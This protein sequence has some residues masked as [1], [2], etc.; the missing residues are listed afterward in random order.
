M[1][2]TDVKDPAPYFQTHVFCC[3][4]EREEGHPRGSC[5]L[6]GRSRCATT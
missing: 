4:N 3:T 2:E 5:K 6:R 1:S